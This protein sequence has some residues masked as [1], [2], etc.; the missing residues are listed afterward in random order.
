MREQNWTRFGL[1]ALA[2]FGFLAIL[3]IALT[4]TDDIE[5]QTWVAEELNVDGAMAA[6]LP[7][8]ELTATF[9][10]G[11]VNGLA[12]CNSF[13]AS[14]EVDGDSI[15]V[16][17]AGATLAFCPAP[18]GI[19]DQEATYLQLISSADNFILDTD[20]S[21]FDTVTREG[22]TLQL[23]SADTTLISYQAADTE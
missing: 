19:M 4:A 17:P 5:G 8:T 13:F 20:P 6:P 3:G 7:G 12:G 18:D 22:D 16:G 11:S 10:D 9:E 14:Y 23:L 21:H 15:S 1:L 2:G